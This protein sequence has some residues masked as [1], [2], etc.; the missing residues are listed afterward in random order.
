VSF[1]PPSQ[2]GKTFV[3][4]GGSRGI[5]YW[6][7]EHLARAGA[8]VIIAAR[9]KEQADAA[10][11]SIR[12]QV[13]NAVVRFVPLD[14]GS[15]D[16][17]AEAARTLVSIG[18]VDGIALNGAVVAGG[19]ERQTTVDGLELIVGTNYVGHFALLAGCFT[20]LTPTARVVG[21]GSMA[22]RMQ[23]VDLDD[24]MQRNGQYSFD[25]AYAYSKHAVQMFGFELD[26]RLRQSGS[27]IQSLVAHPGFALD[28]QA[29]KRAVDPRSTVSVLTQ[30]LLRPMTQGKDRGALPLVRAL[31][32][33][34]LASGSY[35]GPRAGL[36][37]S[38][39]VKTAVAADRDP[40]AAATLWR[41]T[42]QWANLTF[43]I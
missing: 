21:M 26:R 6:I 24:L 32:D 22:T 17:V 8:E 39:V 42:E 14:L 40:N 37:G 36:K 35:I 33:L 3:V 5:G 15:L 1:T 30:N 28:V 10:A 11:E 18:V 23:K 20:A 27:G 13:P 43:S 38:P 31:T 25:S 2:A 16:S 29:P 9:S 19:K 41:L 4:T 12:T 7:A 34:S